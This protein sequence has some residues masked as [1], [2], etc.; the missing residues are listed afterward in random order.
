MAENPLAARSA[1]ACLLVAVGNGRGVTVMDRDGLGL[2]TLAAH[3]GRRAALA[4]RIRDEFHVE[5]PSGPTVAVA[6]DLVFAGTAPG[7]WLAMR[8]RGGNAFATA[9]AQS[10]A[11]LA[12]VTD[13]S[14]GY[15]LLR[16]TGP[17]V[18]AAL[19]KLVPIDLHPREF[20][21]GAVASTVASHM[22]LILWRL[23]D[24]DGAAVFELAVFRSLAESFWHAL[25]EASAEFGVA[26]GRPC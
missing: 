22:G 15:A 13:Q 6:A 3:R 24:A 25:A 12:A 7:T 9:L 21:P 4:A 2:A 8:D 11:G 17:M 20:R 10:T 14:D 5:L 23:D 19:A 1:F 26:V 16:L 18:R